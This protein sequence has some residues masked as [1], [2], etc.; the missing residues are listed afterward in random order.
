MKFLTELLCYIS[1]NFFSEFLVLSENCENM[2]IYLKVTHEKNL[3][4]SL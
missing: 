2:L 1:D 4:F 3:H